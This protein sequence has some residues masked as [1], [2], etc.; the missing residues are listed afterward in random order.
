MVFITI[1]HN[2]SRYSFIITIYTCAIVLISEVEP[3]NPEEGRLL[4][5]E[6]LQVVA[7]CTIWSA[8]LAESVNW[9][10]SQM[11]TLEYHEP[12]PD[13]ESRAQLTAAIVSDSF[14]GHVKHH[15]RNKSGL[16]PDNP[17]KHGS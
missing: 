16:Y 1:F 7:R 10:I 8:A 15:A 13:Q 14:T 3:S 5:T 12:D 4:F 11:L 17:P 6:L 9:K 2:F